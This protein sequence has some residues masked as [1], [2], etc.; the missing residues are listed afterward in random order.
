[1][2][3]ATQNLKWSRAVRTFVMFGMVSAA[4]V[5]WLGLAGADGEEA[6]GA[7]LH[8]FKSMEDL[9]Q[10]FD[11]DFGAIRIVLLLSPT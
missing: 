2:K 8:D 3:E 6:Q 1:M 7:K 5:A 4:A 11:K 10:T 9:G